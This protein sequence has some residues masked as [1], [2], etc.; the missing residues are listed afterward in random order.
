MA[1]INT[2]W[3]KELEQV[4]A[5]MNKV[6]DEK[7]EPMVDRALDRSVKEVDVALNKV[8]FEM[9]E[10]IKQLALEIEKQKNDFFKK[11]MF[12]VVGVC[13]CVLFLKIYF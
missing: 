13:V 5:T 1:F 9:Q 8:S 2:D 10:A 6:L 3:T 12:L 11:L 7:V 4:E